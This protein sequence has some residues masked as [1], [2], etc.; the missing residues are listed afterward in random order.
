MM[1]N[2]PKG[3][4]YFGPLIQVI[5]DFPLLAVV[6]FERH[7]RTGRRLLDGTA[8]ANDAGAHRPD[9]SCL[10]LLTRAYF[11]PECSSSPHAVPYA[12]GRAAH[13]AAHHPRGRPRQLRGLLQR[14]PRLAAAL[15]ARHQIPDG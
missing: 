14:V 7:P 13:R 5:W 15:P 12:L 4:L 1:F 9:S 10:H 8:Y 3:D 2:L 6:P 11:L